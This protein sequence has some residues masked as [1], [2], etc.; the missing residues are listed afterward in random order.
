MSAEEVCFNMQIPHNR[1]YT[2][3]TIASLLELL[4][5]VATGLRAPQ[6]RL[7]EPASLLCASRNT[8]M[9]AYMKAQLPAM[10]P[11]ATSY[12]FYDALLVIQAPRYGECPT[13]IT[14][15]T[16]TEY[17]EFTAG[18]GYLDIL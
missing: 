2:E 17:T 15:A 11:P 13:G 16:T 5:C 6:I 3:H 10:P 4:C 8:R 18:F 1:N 12:R 7:H 14:H 9:S